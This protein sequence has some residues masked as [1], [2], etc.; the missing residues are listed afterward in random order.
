MR[1]G[2]ILYQWCGSGSGNADGNQPTYSL[3]SLFLQEGSFKT[4]TVL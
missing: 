3:S 1:R 4:K 2:G